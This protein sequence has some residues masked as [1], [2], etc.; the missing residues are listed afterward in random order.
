[1]P[2]DT[3]IQPVLCGSNARALD[4]AARLEA[5]GIWVAAIRPPTVPE[6][7]AR[8]RVTLSASHGEAQVDAVVEALAR[9]RDHVDAASTA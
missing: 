9:A 8:L 3:P 4:M 6:G 5:D 2:S 7:R 1:M